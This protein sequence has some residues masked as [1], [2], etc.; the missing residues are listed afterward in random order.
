M[1]EQI[2]KLGSVYRK[3]GLFGTM[4]KLFQYLASELSAVAGVGNWLEYWLHK[5]NYRN[6]IRRLLVSGDYKRVIVWRSSFGWNVPL[7]QRPQ[8]ISRELS[9]MDTLVIYEVSPMT[10]KVRTMRAVKDGLYLVNFKNTPFVRFLYKELTAC[11]L[12]KYIQ[13]YSTDWTIPVS[14]VEKYI[15]DGFGIIYEYID[16]LSPVLAGTSELP[17]N[18]REKYQFAMKDTEHVLMVV[19]ADRLFRDV[20]EKRGDKNLVFASNGVDYDFFRDIDPRYP[21]DASFQAVLDAGKP[22]IGYYGALASWFDYELLKEIDASGQYSVVLL[23]IKYDGSYDESGVAAC[24]NVHFLGPRD[25]PVLKH[26]AAKMDVLTIPF[27]INDITRATSPLKLFEYMAL[28]KPI[29]T[30]DMDECRKYQSVLIGHNHEEFM[31]MLHK[32]M[33]LR[34]N[35]AYLALLD[36][37]ARENTWREK[38][39]AIVEGLESREQ[40]A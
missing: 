30:T 26:Y 23:G 8:H 28:G 16:D 6:T 10:D 14:A 12:P 9:G 27:V 17:A 29:V 24:R 4:K 37:E 19:T 34:G 31:D 36:R 32:A 15:A 35:A 13:F 3:Y 25:Y 38:A 1:K 11:P 22:I 18:I 7:F 2:S 33:G 21:F 40:S 20:L 5:K 39:S